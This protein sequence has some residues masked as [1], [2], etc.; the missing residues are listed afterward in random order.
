MTIY[1]PV[2]GANSY[3]SV[4]GVAAL[5][6]AWTNDG[7]FLDGDLYEDSTNPS[8]TTVVDWIDQTSAILNTALAKYGFAVPIT[9]AT[10]VMAAASIV[11]QLVADMANYANS[12]GRFFSQRFIDSGYS[13]WRT[14]RND[15]D[16]WVLEYAPGLES[17]GVP[18][19]ES[20]VDKIGFRSH[21]DAGDETFPIF[22]RKG[23]G[24]VFDNWTKR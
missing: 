21:D 23:F 15:I 5:A 13:V 14:I 17:L 4:Q 8:L 24:N 3:G 18:R 2:P 16:A 6:R 7:E 1:D 22:Q 9:Q 20:N 11:E 19:T 10:A 12:T